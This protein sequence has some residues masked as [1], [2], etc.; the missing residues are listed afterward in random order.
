M[1][2]LIKIYVWVKKRYYRNSDA[3]F[4]LSLAFSLLIMAIA[5]SIVAAIDTYLTHSEI[6]QLFEST[7]N[8]KFRLRYLTFPAALIAFLLYKRFKRYDARELD[9]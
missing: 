5:F 8:L 7:F 6:T 2:I 1:E 4:H 9:K 3:A